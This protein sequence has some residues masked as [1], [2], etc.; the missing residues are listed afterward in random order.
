MTLQIA[1]ER[2]S[3]HLDA[4]ALDTFTLDG[5]NRLTQWRDK[6]ANGIVFTNITN[7]GTPL[8]VANAVRF[9]PP[10][11][12]VSVTQPSRAR[13]M[14]YNGPVF[15]SYPFDVFAVL[16]R[17]NNPVNHIAPV[18][19]AAN[20]NQFYEFLHHRGV[21]H[22][23]AGSFLHREI[24]VDWTGNQGNLLHGLLTSTQQTIRAQI[25]QTQTW[26]TTARTAYGSVAYLGAERPATSGFPAY[27]L[28]AD[29]HEIIVIKNATDVERG[30]VNHYLAEKWPDLSLAP[31]ASRAIDLRGL[32]N[33]RVALFEY[34][35]P[36]KYTLPGVNA[37]GN[38]R[39]AWPKN[40]PFGIYYL[41]S[42][43][44]CPPI[45]HGP[46]EINQ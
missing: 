42:D 24:A 20:T 23:S 31:V 10:S 1:P 16:S 39:T 37:E 6:N 30:M 43:D 14:Q 8:K 3:L 5:S 2:I 26:D 29:V 7:Y 17:C 41:S 32:P 35:A 22:R 46:Y 13:I 11:V 12:D 36:Q 27:Q 44:R 19:A 28:S 45:C 33:P 25:I 34:A 18:I 21:L 15:N 9:D 40:N 38:W 4:T